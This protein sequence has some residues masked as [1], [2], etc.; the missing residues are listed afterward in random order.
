MAS[1]KIT[2]QAFYKWMLK[3]NDDLFSGL[4]LPD[5]MNKDVL[6]NNILM[7]SAP[8]EV[9]YSD[10]EVLQFMI[11]TWSDAHA[12][13]WQ[14]WYDAWEDS[15]AFNPLENFDRSEHEVIQ[16]SGTDQENNTQTRNL[17]GSDNR[18]ADLTNQ[19]T[20]NYSDNETR[21]LT[22]EHTVSAYDASG[23]VP[24]DRDT[25]TG[26]DNIA[27]TGTSTV[28][29]T[30]TDNRAL[31]DTGTVT[32]AGTYVHGHKIERDSRFHGNIGV[33]SLSTLLKDYN[34]VADQWDLYAV[35]TNQFLTEFCLLVY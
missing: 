35:I 5:G 19:E 22:D 12:D 16:N 20:R 8:F 4:T 18:T 25:H 30:G 34:A 33:T 17:S 11:G 31:S 6:V 2:V 7:A 13:M 1:A 23:Y 21:N 28:K 29:N 26:T 10:P 32:D 24:K 9:V 15:E 14:R 27:H 3:D